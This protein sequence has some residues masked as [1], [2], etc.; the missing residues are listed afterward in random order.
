MILN[1]LSL[2][3]VHTG[4]AVSMWKSSTFAAIIS[5]VALFALLFIPLV[6][7]HYRSFGSVNAQRLIGAGMFSVYGVAIFTFTLL[8]LPDPA[9]MRCT[10]SREPN[11]LPGQSLFKAIDDTAGWSWTERLLSAHFLQLPFNILLFIPLGLFLCGYFRWSKTSAT[12]TAIALSFLIEC[13]QATGMWWLLPCPHRFGDI[14]DLIL[15]SLGGFIGALCAPLLWRLFPDAH[16]LHAKR[17]APRPLSVSRRFIGMLFDTLFVLLIEVGLFA[18]VGLFMIG[19]QRVIENV[20]LEALTF[21]PPG[22]LAPLLVL[23][24]AIIVFYLPACFG[25]GASIGQRLVWLSFVTKE[26]EAPSLRRRIVRASASAGLLL[27][28]QCLWAL[29]HWRAEFYG[30]NLIDIGTRGVGIMLVLSVVSVL[31]T[32]NSRGLSA[33]IAGLELVDRRSVEQR[34]TVNASQ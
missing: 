6:I 33:T 18:T 13:T 26:G 29:P 28:F 8:P 32:R 11:F 2:A 30:V 25:H 10:R 20:P 24:A 17:D 19:Y 16:E 12:L 14:D 21:N 3:I 34:I 15:N 27:F 23:V 5:G 9:T 31:F 7:S 22:W 1:A 4:D